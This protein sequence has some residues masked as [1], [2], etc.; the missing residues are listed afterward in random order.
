MTPPSTPK[1]AAHTDKPKR[2]SAATKRRL[3]NAAAEEFANRGVAGARVDRIAAA[4]QANKRLI[5]DYFGD[6]DGLFDAVIDSYIDH[7]V[8]AVPI[9]ANDLPAYAGRLFDYTIDNADLLRLLTWARLERRITPDSRARS[10]ASY[11]RRL[12][13]IENA[14][15]EGRVTSTF[16]P[17]QIL[18]LIESLVVGWNGTTQA[19]QT[20][21][22]AE[23]GRDAQRKTVEE[24]VRRMLATK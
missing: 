22:G 9:D 13:S 21:D 17:V 1:T 23:L 16:T 19:F 14:Q 3:L 5:Y 12:A 15:R 18:A 4:A 8:D 7:I 2:D 10:A 20:K 24:A 11:K 6:K